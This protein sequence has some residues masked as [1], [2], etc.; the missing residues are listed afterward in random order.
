MW[1][2]DHKEG[3]AP[4]NW[5][6]WTVVLEKT[7]GSPLDSTEIQL[8]HPKGNQSWIFIGRKLKL[9]YFGK[10][11]EEPTHWQRPWCWERLRAKG[12]END[13]GWD[14]WMASLTQWT[15]IWAH[16]R[17]WWRTGKSGV[18]QSMRSDTKSQIQLSDWT[19]ILWCIN[20]SDWFLFFLPPTEA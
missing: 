1:Q 17:R 19:T 8:V 4:K 2:V 13:R 9:Q 10:V 11:R 14:G 15:C 16:S 20:I 3:W 7:L 12:E 5:C 18:L 6:F